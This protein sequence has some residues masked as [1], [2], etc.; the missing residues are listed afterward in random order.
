MTDG[1]VDLLGIPG[2]VDAVEIG[3]GGFGTVYRARQPAL[4]RVVA[5][6]VLHGPAPDGRARTRFER[7]CAAMGSLSGHP[8]VA[9]VY[10]AGATADGR[11][12][13]LLEFLE[14]GTLAERI[15]RAG[16][17]PPHDVARIGAAVARGLHAAHE[18][19]LVHCDVT[20]ANVLLARD[21]TP[22]LTDFGI[23]RAVDREV[24]TV[25]TAPL[26]H[27][28]PEVVSGK[29]ASE[30]ADVY[31]LGSTLY[32][33][34]AGRS[35]FWSDDDETAAPLI[36]RILTQPVPD[37]RPLGVPAPL[38]TTVEAAMAKD[39]AARPASALAL[40]D[41][42]EGALTAAPP[43]SSGPGPG[44]GARGRP[45]LDEV[46]VVGAF[47]VVARVTSSSRRDAAPYRQELVIP[48]GRQLPAPPFTWGE[49]RFSSRNGVHYLTRAYAASF[50]APDGR[51]VPH[52]WTVEMTDAFRVVDAE[53]DGSR[54]IAGSLEGT[55]VYEALPTPEGLAAGCV[56]VR[57]TYATS[58]TRRRG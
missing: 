18:Q 5:V 17:L 46:A 20:P 35:A 4:G 14:G 42:L 48:A 8:H 6:K 54:W 22:K 55:A 47:E 41:A 58:F 19:G 29:P 26:V 50:T 27:A 1:G 34:L 39:A 40:A 3:R 31:S 28:A 30:A 51:Q 38:A 32:Q 45:P 12:Y 2:V 9:T 21:G 23:S 53:W 43:P 37:L 44:V 56:E 10:D 25:F 57:T 36:A 33:A 16:P 15:R 52:A 13:L 49:F 7:E 11:L 24:S